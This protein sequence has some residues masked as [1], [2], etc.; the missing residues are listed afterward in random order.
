MQSLRSSG[1]DS[2]Q[3]PSVDAVRISKADVSAYQKECI[4]QEV[5][6]AVNALRVVGIVWIDSG[7]HNVLYH[8]NDLKLCNGEGLVNQPEMTAI[9]GL[10]AVS[11]T[12]KSPTIL[13]RLGGGD[14]V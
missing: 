11:G 1:T 10:E 5:P 9:F 4:Y 12:K 14:G 7:T 2:P 3:W 8:E 13:T 6:A